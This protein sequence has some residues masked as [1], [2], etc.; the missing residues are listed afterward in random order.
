MEVYSGS[1]KTIQLN[2]W[3]IYFF[4]FKVHSYE[5]ISPVRHVYEFGIFLR[6]D[7]ALQFKFAQILFAKVF[8]IYFQR[9]NI[10][11]AEYCAMDPVKCYCAF[12]YCLLQHTWVILKFIRFC[13]THLYWASTD[14]LS[15]HRNTS[16]G[17]ED[18]LQRFRVF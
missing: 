5:N 2:L 15:R 17:F 13:L 7:F 14:S 8:C 9:V 6:W 10:P 4:S 11:W 1:H 18:Y 16:T 3:Q 12:V